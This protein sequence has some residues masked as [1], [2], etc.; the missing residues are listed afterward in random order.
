[1]AEKLV[2]E[3]KEIVI[4]GEILAEGMNFLPGK[5]AFRDGKNICS[6]SLGLINVNGRVINVI[7]L[8]GTYVPKIDDMIIGRVTEVSHA[9]WYINI[10]CAYSADLNVKE[11][12]RRYVEA[13]LSKFLGIGEYI[14]AKITFEI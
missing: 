2:V 9:G 14:F 10:D 4:P 12:S 6:S 1:M 7:P 5:R 11:A 3:N 13:P 8:S